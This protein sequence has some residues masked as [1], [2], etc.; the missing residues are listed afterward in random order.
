[1]GI[2]SALYK[3]VKISSLTFLSRLYHLWLCTVCN[4][5][6]IFSLGCDRISNHTLVYHSLLDNI[7]HSVVRDACLRTSLTGT[8]LCRHMR[9]DLCSLLKIA[10]HRLERYLDHHHLSCAYQICFDLKC[11]SDQPPFE[12]KSR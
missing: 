1:M 3:H 6:C 4:H 11:V 2:L 9:L 12:E 5:I 7:R 10:P 8:G